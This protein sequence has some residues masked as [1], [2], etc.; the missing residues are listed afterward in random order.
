MLMRRYGIIT[1]TMLLLVSCTG[2]DGDGALAE[3][4]VST[5]I[6]NRPVNVASGRLLVKTVSGTADFGLQKIN[7][8]DVSVEPLFP[9]VQD[10]AVSSALDCWYLLKFSHDVG[11]EEIACAVAAD[12][13]VERVQYD[14]LMEPVFSDPY[15]VQDPVSTKSSVRRMTR[16]NEEMPFDDPELPWQ[17]HYFNDESLDDGEGRFVA[18]ADINLFEAWKYS[19]G[20][21]RIVV[22]VL[23]GG[24]MH[25]HED[26][27]A[28]MWVNEAEQTGSEGVDDDGN[29][30]VDDVYGYNFFHDSAQIDWDETNMRSHGTHLAGTI[31]AVNNNGLY[32]SG[33]AGGSGNNDG[34]RI[35][36]CQIFHDGN[37]TPESNI[38]RAVKYAA[39]NGAVI[40][41]NSWAYP[42][43]TYTSDSRFNANYSVL[44]DAFRYFEQNGGYDGLIDGG[45]LIFAAGNDGKGV[46]AYPGAYYD[47]ICVTAMGPDFLAASYTNYGTGANICAP[48]GEGGAS[49]FGTI[50]KISSTSV[51]PDGYEYM[52]GTSM[53]APHVA[54]SAALA[55]SYALELGR[56]FTLDEFKDM[57][58][59][60]VHDVD[61]YQTGTKFCYISGDAGWADVDMSAYAGKLGSGYIDAHRLLMQVEGVPCLYF[62]AGTDVGLPLSVHFGGGSEKLVYTGVTAEDEAVRT[63]GIE[64]ISVE[65]GLLKV[66]CSNTGTARVQV[67]A[68]IGGSSVGG[69]DTMGGME[70]SRDFML[71]VRRKASE[72]GG[73]L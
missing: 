16:S 39:D 61:Q 72:N 52:H 30:Y 12:R 43:G 58:L 21:P 59:T 46:P 63:L 9:S 49:G 22:A 36:A 65:D 23:D 55:L 37:A 10:D 34:C 5:K 38:A 40:I 51:D 17:W 7:G 68:I 62:T 8:V 27:A 69:G 44:M 18:G 47:H 54:G 67:T 64:S 2:R 73:W 4:T 41:N 32:V 25:T 56:S 42:S 31:A 45:L 28:N 20:D 3:D 66:R 1:L 19:T 15:D 57:I 60:S 35:M 48:G 13:R 11:L 50:H 33:I 26:L 53:A 29:G 71:V 6:I 24:I 70:V 14:V